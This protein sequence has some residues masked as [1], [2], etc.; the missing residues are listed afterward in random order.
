MALP[1]SGQLSLRDIGAELGIIPGNQA[2][3]RSMASAAGFTAPDEVSDFYGYSAGD[4]ITYAWGSTTTVTSNST[5]T[6][7]YRVLNLSGQN[8]T[9][10]RTYINFIISM[11]I[12]VGTVYYSLNSTS[13]WTTLFSFSSPGI[14]TTVYVPSSPTYK[15]PSQTLRVRIYSSHAPWGGGGG[16]AVIQSS[17]QVGSGTVDSYTAGTPTSWT[18][19]L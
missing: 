7:V 3:M 5:I 17:Y 2:S 18:F 12:G 10:I 14:N 15:S 11:S 1:S 6:D 16:S 9:N 8:S 19:S 13:S 4:N